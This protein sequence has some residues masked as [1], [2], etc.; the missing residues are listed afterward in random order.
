M[1][2]TILNVGRVRQQFIK[3]GEEEYAKRLKGT[4]CAIELVELSL[5]APES[6]SPDV[7]REREG[8]ELEKRLGRF[9]FV[10]M[11]DE[12]GSQLSSESFAQLIEGWMRDGIRSVAFVIG[13]AFGFSDGVRSKADYLLS[14]SKFTLPHQLARLVLVEQIYRAHTLI[15]GISYHKR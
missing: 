9:D 7:V 13:G 11:L 1:K 5:D 4:P 8:V 12:R 14:L 15:R 6:L 3:A 2:L 10:V